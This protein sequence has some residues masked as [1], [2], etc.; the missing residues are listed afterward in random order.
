MKCLWK[1]HR[2]SGV[3]KKKKNCKELSEK[4]VQSDPEPPFGVGLGDTLASS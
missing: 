2:G 3:K 4:F 1:K